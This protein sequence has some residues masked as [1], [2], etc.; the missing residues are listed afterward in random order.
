MSDILKT[1]SATCPDCDASLPVNAPDGLC[2]ACL[3]RTAFRAVFDS[4]E[5]AESNPTERQHLEL[6]PN[7]QLVL[8]SQL[9]FL[10][11]PGWR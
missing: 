6:T 10:I 5:H 3:L 2:P 8:L 1:A 11:Q 9:L 4:A 7:A